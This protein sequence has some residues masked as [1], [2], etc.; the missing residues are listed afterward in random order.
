MLHGMKIGVA[1]AVLLG[2]GIG[3]VQAESLKAALAS[4][5]ANNPT[6]TSALMSVKV[7]AENIALRKSAI[8]PNIGAAVSTTSSFTSV[9]GSGTG[10]GTTLGQST[11]AGL[12]YTQTLFDNNKTNAN[13]EQARAL[14]AFCTL[15]VI[16][17]W[18]FWW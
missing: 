4:S 9:P 16:A 11:T 3:G 15:L 12:S 17:L 10:T 7:A 6:I 8:L 13:V 18:R 14:A 5:Y 1:A 2:L